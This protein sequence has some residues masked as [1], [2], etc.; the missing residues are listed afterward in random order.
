MAQPQADL[1]QHLLQD[2]VAIARVIEA[3]RLQP[4]ETVLDAGAGA[5]ALSGPAATAV[6][7]EGRVYAVEIDP[8]MLTAL[9]EHAKPPLEVLE[10]NLVN[11]PFPPKIDAVVANPPFKIAAHFL[12]RVAKK[13]IPR[14]VLVLPRELVDR[15]TATPGSERYGKLTIRMALL[16][17]VEDL[18]DISRYAFNPAPKVACGLLRMKTRTDVPPIKPS[19]LDDVLDAAHAAWKKKAKGAF[20]TLVQ[21]ARIDSAQFT[22]MLREEGWADTRTS[23][24]PPEAFAKVAR[25][26]LAH[27]PAAPAG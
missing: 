15:L 14:A 4:G 17:D 2:A 13:G 24:L 5:G 8:V 12:E 19:V 23:S 22:A 18:G 20:E 26:L 9:R 16:A 27:A 11:M 1:G 3:A 7:L 6:G 10:G 21:A 25:Y